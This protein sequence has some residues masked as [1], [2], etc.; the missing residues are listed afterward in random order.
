MDH[1]ESYNSSKIA[2]VNLDFYNCLQRGRDFYFSVH[3]TL[4]QW[5]FPKTHRGTGA[6]PE[7]EKKTNEVWTFFLKVSAQGGLVRFFL[8]F[9]F[10]S[11]EKQTLHAMNAHSQMH[12][13]A[14]MPENHPERLICSTLGP[15]IRRLHFK[16]KA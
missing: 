7:A 15:K 2:G 1:K 9:H 14:R 12:T 10:P 6:R 13:L 16:Y 4:R 3:K 8:S 11:F 5:H